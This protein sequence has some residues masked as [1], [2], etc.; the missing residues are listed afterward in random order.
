MSS[1]R[2]TVLSSLAPK[3]SILK[4]NQECRQSARPSR[5]MHQITRCGGFHSRGTSTSI[6][7]LKRISYNKNHHKTST[8]VVCGSVEGDRQDPVQPQ[9]VETP[10][11][12][13]LSE[14]SKKIN[15]LS[16]G[17]KAQVERLEGLGLTRPNMRLAVAG[18]YSEIKL[19]ALM[20]QVLNGDVK[21][22]SEVFKV[23]DDLQLRLQDLITDM[24]GDEEDEK[25]PGQ[26]DKIQSML[27]DSTN[28]TED[29]K[30]EMGGMIGNIAY[31]GIQSF[32]WSTILLVIVGLSI[33][34]FLRGG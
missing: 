7:G 33:F 29:E 2:V 9:P 23:F 27:V 5:R 13:P 26:F 12:P 34:N 24:G 15:E 4:S 11:P 6:P 21:E 32:F 28:L 8:G 3:V 1:G 31:N 30:A 20:E 17:I 14:E 22:T 19:V 18:E 10:P 25:E 16:S